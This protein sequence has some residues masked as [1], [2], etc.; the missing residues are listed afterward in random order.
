MLNTVRLRWKP[1]KPWVCVWH[2]HLH[3]TLEKYYIQK[4][5]QSLEKSDCVRIAFQNPG[6]CG[7]GADKEKTL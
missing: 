5:P 6:F 4:R 2:R 3:G 7:F 1:W